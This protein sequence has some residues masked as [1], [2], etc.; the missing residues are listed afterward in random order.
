[1]TTLSSAPLAP[2]L[3]DMFAE[4]EGQISPARSVASAQITRQEHERLRMSTAEA[5]YRRLFGILK[6]AY[7]AVSRETALLLYMLARSI[8][9][10]HIVEFGSSLGISTLHLAAA[11][12]DNGGGQIVTTELESTKA[13]RARRNFAA[14]GL[15]DLIELREGDALRTLAHDLPVQIDLVL[16]D[17]TK[18]LYAAVLELL[19]T[20]LSPGALLVADNAERSPGYLARVRSTTSGYVSV[21]VAAD[22]ELSMRTC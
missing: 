22:V 1:M 9:A 18:P 7:M 4:A 3:D 5:D 19:E 20:H 17:G 15:D 10:R 2:L 12:R 21:P 6:D 13:A 11:L 8:G 16:L 14:G